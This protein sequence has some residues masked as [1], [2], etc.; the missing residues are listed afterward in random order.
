MGGWREG[1]ERRGFREG[2][3]ESKCYISFY[4]SVIESKVYVFE[5]PSP[6]H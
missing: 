1:K 5:F 2:G 6:K 3:S 4:D